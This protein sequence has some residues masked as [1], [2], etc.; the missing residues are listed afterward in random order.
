MTPH[1]F[2]IGANLAHESYAADLPQVLERARNA[3][4]QRLA[5]TGSDLVSSLFAVERAAQTPETFVATAGLHPHHADSWDANCKARFAELVRRPEVKAVGET[6]LDYFRN[7][8]DPKRQRACLSEQLESAVAVGK[9]VFLHQRD[10][11][12]D[13][14][15]IVR[16]FR[17]QLRQAVV[18]CFTGTGDELDDWLALDM[19]IGITGWV[20]DERRGLGLRDLIAHIP[21]H[22]LM[23]ETDA[24]YLRP[25]DLPAA[26]LAL[27]PDRHRNEPCTLP[28]ILDT[29]AACRGVDSAE[30]AA[31][32]W[33]TSTAF[34]DC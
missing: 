26:Q 24:P 10:A 5:L 3:G 7:L 30:L 34:F 23:L 33:N 8:A 2:D 25:R 13:M 11:H 18:H 15:A 19:H 29:V 9:N 1:L 4:V 12:P 14:L 16:E 27:L 32:I 22:R 6:G 20:C 21:A 31:Q 28:H 17:P